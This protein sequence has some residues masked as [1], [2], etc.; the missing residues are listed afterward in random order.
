MV[1]SCMCVG[2]G[3]ILL[4]RVIGV[5]LNLWFWLVCSVVMLVLSSCWLLSWVILKM[6]MRLVLIWWIWLVMLMVGLL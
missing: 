5:V 4:F 3:G 2:W 6:C 1:C